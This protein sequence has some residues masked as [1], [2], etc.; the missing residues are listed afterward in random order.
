MEGLILIVIGV[1]G[2]IAFTKYKYEMQML[3][4]VGMFAL[5]LA[6][7]IRA[8]I[9][10]GSVAVAVTLCV[11]GL[12]FCCI[13]YMII[14]GIKQEKEQEPKRLAEQKHEKYNLE[15]EQGIYY[16]MFEF[17]KISYARSK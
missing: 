5:W 11:L 14:K 15:H 1:V 10:E 13:G 12:L 6:Y 17:L 16:N 4:G 2:Y 3:F 9:I 7:I 8:I